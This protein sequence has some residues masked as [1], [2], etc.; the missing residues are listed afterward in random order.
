MVGRPVL[1]L[2][3]GV[4]PRIVCHICLRL[5][6]DPLPVRREPRVLRR[7]GQLS[8]RRSRVRHEHLVLQRC[9]CQLLLVHGGLPGD[10]LLVPVVVERKVIL[11]R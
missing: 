8:C 1:E 2:D 9:V 4:F 5:K 11:E 3:Q 10:P 6:R 7:G